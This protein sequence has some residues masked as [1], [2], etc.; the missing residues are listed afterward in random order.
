L[1][2]AQPATRRIGVL[3]YGGPD[4]WASQAQAAGLRE[5]LK[6]AGWIEGRN[7]RIDLRVDSNPDR[8]QARA[9]ELVATAPDA[10]VVNTNRAAKALQ[11]ATRT[12]PIVFAGVGDPVAN[13]LVASLNRPGGNVTGITNL[14][15][16]IGGKWLEL[17]KEAVPRLSRTAIMFNPD[18]IA[19]EDWFAAIEEAAPMFG[20]TLTK[21]P[22]RN[23]ADIERAITQFSAV[24]DGALIIVPPGLVG[25]DRELVLHLTRERR[26]PAIYSARTYSVDGGLMSYG[27]DSADL[28]RQSASYVDRILR[29]A[30]P[31]ELPVQFPSKFELVINRRTAKAMGLDIPP[32]LIARA[33]ELIE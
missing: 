29:G 7:L 4:N 27:P 26:L 18:L 16:S 24:P 19:R 10:I 28:F 23:L 6:E 12:I 13:G 15:F 5:G 30:K 1:A 33:D 31:G 11:Q 9:E 8:I 17:L 20:V 25:A 2:P 21:L 32:T 14:F 3:I 22:V